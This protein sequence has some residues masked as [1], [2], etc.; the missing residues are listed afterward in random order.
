MIRPAPPSPAPAPAAGPPDSPCIRQCCLDEADTCLGCGR[1]L[2]EILRWH[3][4]DDADKRAI[5]ALAAARREAR[6]RR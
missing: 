5:L 6:A 4:A 1:L 3:R 2:E